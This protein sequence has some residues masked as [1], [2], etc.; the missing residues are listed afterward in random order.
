MQDV[1]ALGRGYRMN[2]PG[3]AEGNWHW[4]FAWEQLPPDLLERLARMAR[5]YGRV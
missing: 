2:T 5:L 1:L 3:T 4:R